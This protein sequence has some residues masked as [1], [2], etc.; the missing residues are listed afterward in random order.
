MAVPHWTPRTETTRREQML[1][2]RVGRTRKL[3]GFL[4]IYRSQLFNEAFQEELASMYRDTGEGRQPVA[5]AL[6]A[7]VILLQAYANVSDAEAVDLSV[8]DARWQMVL[9]T[10][11]AEEPPFSQGALQAFRERLIAHDMDRRLL[12]RTV[13]LAKETGAFDYKKLPKTLRLAVDSRPLQ[14]AGRVEDTFNLL[15]HAARKLLVCAAALTGHEAKSITKLAQT[16]L[17]LSSSIKRGLDIDWTDKAQK[18]EALADLLEQIESL[19]NLV[20]DHLVEQ[21]DQPPLAEHLATLKQL[22]E[23]DLEPDP[24]DPSGSKQRIRDGVAEDRRI[25][26]EDPEMR[27]GRKS[28]RRTINGYKS[29]LG[30][31][32]DT[33]LVLAC[34]VTPAN[35]PEAEALGSIAADIGQF[36]ER[37]RVA[38]LYIDRGYLASETTQQLAA[39]DTEIVCKPW[40]KRAGELF[41]KQDFFIDL[42]RKTI[43]CPAGNTEPFELGSTVQFDAPTC[44]T[45]PKRAQCTTAAP[46]HGRTV[47]IAKD[48]PLQQKLRKA[49]STKAGREKLRKRTAVEHKLAHLSR[50]QGPRARY[51]GTRKNLFDLRRHSAN[52]N[53]ERVQS[54][55]AA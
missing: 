10:L 52:L 33:D 7:M 28:K 49:A 5:P 19:E 24:S 3:F 55:K 51:K 36:P 2:K 4:R 25:S 54:A 41:S 44:A 30:M 26:I 12:E 27:H 22:R 39:N 53:L 37:T 50:K 31:D 42:R 45:C 16:P 8:V 1:L 13:E 11:G 6:L 17:L 38:E 15:A 32:L 21:A 9:D 18:E 14:G 47:T 34:A 20:Q 40:P 46:G 48:E 35:Q 29:H 23:Q 43:T